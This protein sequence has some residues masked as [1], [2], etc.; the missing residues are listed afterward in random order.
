MQSIYNQNSDGYESKS[1]KKTEKKSGQPIEKKT[2]KKTEK[3][4]DYIESCVYDADRLYEDLKKRIVE[5]PLFAQKPDSEKID[6]YQKSEFKEFYI[7]F[8]IVS[9]YMIC[10]GQYNAKAFKKF[11]IKCQNTKSTERKET[12]TPEELWVQRQADYIK[13]L[14]ESYQKPHFNREHANDIWRHAYK[15][16]LNEFKDFKDLHKTIEDR[17][18]V[19]D[20]NNK[21]SMVKELLH[22]ISN[23]EQTLDSDSSK[24]LIIKLQDQIFVQRKNKVLA[25][26]KDRRR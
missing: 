4:T 20:K 2:E 24:E 15:T 12:D 26:I 5:D 21:T 25:D 17:L 16:L 7:G 18:K 14:W 8:P 10:M 3:P 22:R 1:K 13:Y 6:I 11:L 9:R 23:N 19:D